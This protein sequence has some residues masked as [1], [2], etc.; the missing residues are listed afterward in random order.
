MTFL[1]RVRPDGP[2]PATG[3]SGA[4]DLLARSAMELAARGLL[5]GAGIGAILAAGGR[6][7]TIAVVFAGILAIGAAIAELGA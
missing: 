4:P 1:E 5:L 2:H 3:Q 6:D 7:G